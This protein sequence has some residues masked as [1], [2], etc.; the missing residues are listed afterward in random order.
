M[1]NYV[2]WVTPRGGH[3]RLDRM[4]LVASISFDMAG[5]AIFLPLLA[6]GAVLPVREVNA[7]TLREVL[8]D[9][10]ATAM[11]IT[12]SHLEHHQ[13][14]RRPPHDDARGHDHRRSAAPVDGPARQGGSR[15]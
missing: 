6:G 7:V 15:P 8:E 14:G 4:P 5:C 1:V 12:P 9:S 3:R 2:R 10:G 11:A 13:P